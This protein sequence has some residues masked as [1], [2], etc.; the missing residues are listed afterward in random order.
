[1]STYSYREVLNQI[2]HLSVDEQLQ[3]LEDIAKL[4][5]RQTVVKPLHSILELE[6]LGKETWKDVDIDQYIEQERSSWDG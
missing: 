4:L 6:G 1:M 3:L 2:Q 5:R